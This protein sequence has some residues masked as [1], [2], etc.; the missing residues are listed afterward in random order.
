MKHYVALFYLFLFSLLFAGENYN[1]SSDVFTESPT[2]ITY[3]VTFTMSSDATGNFYSEALW[4]GDAN[5]SDGWIYIT[6]T[7]ET[8]TEDVDF[9]LQTSLDA[10]TWTTSSADDELTQVG[11]TA[12]NDT[13]GV[14]DGTDDV[15]FHRKPWL[16]IKGDGQTGNPGSVV[17]IFVTVKKVA[18]G[19]DYRAGKTK[20]S[21]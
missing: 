13:L 10:S 8:G 20:R 11:T 5:T 19:R 17:T 21:N 16:R 7:N 12:V 15:N 6:Q 3:K 9:T 14:I 18:H 2:I 1:Q 4:V